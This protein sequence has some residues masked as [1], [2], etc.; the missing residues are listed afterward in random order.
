MFT[1]LIITLHGKFWKEDL[2]RP[3]TPTFLS[4]PFLSWLSLSSHTA[5]PRTRERS[6]KQAIFTWRAAS[7]D[8]VMP[9]TK[10]MPRGVTRDLTD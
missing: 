2:E 7:S 1:D 10:Q 5:P 4:Q 3:G 6:G 8:V 9:N